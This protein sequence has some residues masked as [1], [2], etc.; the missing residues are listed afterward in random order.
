MAYKSFNV[1]GTLAHPSEG[2]YTPT[3][4]WL[5][6]L[7]GTVTLAAP[8]TCHIYPSLSGLHN[9]SAYCSEYF[10]PP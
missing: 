5:T 7:Q 8:Q 10:P 2:T 6:L 1:T 4:L 9:C 3:L